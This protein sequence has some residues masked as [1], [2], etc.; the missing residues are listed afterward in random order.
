[1]AKISKRVRRGLFRL[2]IIGSLCAAAYGY[3]HGVE[4]RQPWRM[5]TFRIV[6]RARDELRS[7]MC[8]SVAMARVPPNSSS[9]I[10]TTCWNLVMARGFGRDVQATRFDPRVGVQEADLRAGWDHEYG[11]YATRGGAIQAGVNFVIAWFFYVLVL[12]A[13]KVGL[14]VIDGFRRE[15]SART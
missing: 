14:W 2:C 7:G 15:P 5:E 1:M 10:G 11:L 8:G 3:V 13:I 6:E 4:E 9:V 12:G